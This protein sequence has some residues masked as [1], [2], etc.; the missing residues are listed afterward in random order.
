MKSEFTEFSY[1]FAFTYELASTL[2]GIK[3]A[4]KIPTL[5]EEGKV[6]PDVQLE[7]PGRIYF[8]QYKLTDFLTRPNAKY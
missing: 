6:G 4:P 7:F 1:A 5:Q 8:F 2:P 3:A